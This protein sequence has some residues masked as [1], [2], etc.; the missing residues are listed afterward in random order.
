MQSNNQG[1][2]AEGELKVFQLTYYVMQ[3][4]N[5]D[6]LGR[7]WNIGLPSQIEYK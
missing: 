3:K 5:V 2:K 4:A 7:L 6:Y 1:L